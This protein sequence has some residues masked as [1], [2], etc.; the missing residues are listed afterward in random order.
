MP[1]QPVSA[2]SRAL[3]RTLQRGTHPRAVEVA[4]CLALVVALGGCGGVGDQ[5][6]TDPTSAVVVVGVL[7]S[8]T[9]DFLEVEATAVVGGIRGTVTVEEGSVVLRGIPFGTG[10]PPT[11]PLTVTARGYVTAAYLVQISVTTATFETVTLEPANLENTGI[12]EGRI[13]ESTTGDPITSAL[14]T[15][16][17]EQ[18][19]VDDPVLVSAYTDR[20]GYYIIGG[21]PIGRVDVTAAAAGY[22]GSTTV[23]NVA[24]AAGSTT[25][26]T[27]D[28]ALV[29]GETRVPVS[30]RVVD[31]T[32]QA[33]IAGA[34]I[35]IGEQEP[36]LSAANGA[37]SVANVLVGEESLVVK[38][39]GYDDY[40]E[41]ITVLPGMTPLLVQMNTAA[42]DPPPPPYTITGTVTLVGAEDNSGAQVEAFDVYNAVVAARTTTNAGGQYWLFVPASRYTITVSYGSRQIS[43]TIDLPGG[44]QKLDGIDFTLTV[45]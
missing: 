1:L 31:V 39:D 11:Q 28:L 29:P 26:Q 32:T 22:L 13:T 25:A 44:G 27:L 37:F 40:R 41:T 8:E 20:G 17:Y 15:F 30:G 23:F 9:E 3:C 21:V 24:Q 18:I 43:R 4:C 19:G 5:I 34:Q 16:Q 6:P 38:A 45:E 36:V 35:T 12:I 10:T 2:L 7:D 33:P 14:V 42:P